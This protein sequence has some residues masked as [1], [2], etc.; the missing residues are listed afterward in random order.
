MGETNER[1]KERKPEGESKRKG[2]KG[3]TIV[4]GEEGGMNEERKR[5]R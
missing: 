4:P 3:E 2:R 1:G 5:R